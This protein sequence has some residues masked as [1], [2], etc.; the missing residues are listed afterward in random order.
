MRFFQAFLKKKHRNGFNNAV[1][2][3]CSQPWSGGNG[4]DMN[5]AV[6]IHAGNWRKG[7]P[8]H[9]AYISSLHGLRSRDWFIGSQEIRHAND[10]NY[11]IWIIRTS[12]GARWRYYYDVT[13]LQR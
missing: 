12:A 6:V 13:N 10:R 9:Y 8:A 11:E 7:L 3:E 5:H 1:A 4:I 2:R